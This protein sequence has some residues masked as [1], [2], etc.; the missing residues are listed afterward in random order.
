M[1]LITRTLIVSF[2]SILFGCN[3]NA[4]YKNIDADAFAK[5][6]KT[7]KA[8][9]ID[10]RTEGEVAE[11]FISGTTVFANVNGPDFMQKIK[12]LDPTKTYIVYCRSG[13]RSARA[14]EILT[15]NGF[16]K[17]YNLNGGIMNWRGDISK[18]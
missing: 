18:P 12:A 6:V 15:N 10:V 11:G 14:S 3:A 17:V 9:V 7:E 8:I 2:F 1:N 5:T 16:K 4:Q 13:A